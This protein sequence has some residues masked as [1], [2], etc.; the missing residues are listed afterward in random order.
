MDLPKPKDI[1]FYQM[2][3]KEQNKYYAQHVRGLIAWLLEQED[4]PAK[5]RRP[6]ETIDDYTYYLGYEIGL[7]QTE[8]DNV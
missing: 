7:N 6:I 4:L 2:K 1:N 8:D 3:R 5:F